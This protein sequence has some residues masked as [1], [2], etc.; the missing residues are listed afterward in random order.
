MENA[1]LV[2]IENAKVIYR[3]WMRTVDLIPQDHLR[4]KA[5]S[6]AGQLRDLIM[7][8]ENEYQAGLK[9]HAKVTLKEID[10]FI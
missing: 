2:K 7:R 9:D 5:T 4:A 1:L 3:R 6:R 8:A 10:S